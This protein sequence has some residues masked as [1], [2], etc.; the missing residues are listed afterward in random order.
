[1]ARPWQAS[2][3]R[4]EGWRGPGRGR[5]LSAPWVAPADG[6][7]GRISFGHAVDIPED[8]APPRRRGGRV[9]VVWWSVLLWLRTMFPARRDGR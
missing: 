9:A 8:L 5:G 6:F 1:M 7:S 4:A 3:L 2:P